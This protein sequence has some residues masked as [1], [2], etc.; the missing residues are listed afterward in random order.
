RYVTEYTYDAFSNQLT[1]TR[2]TN[3]ILEIYFTGSEAAATDEF[4]S[5]PTLNDVQTWLVVDAANDRTIETDY[6]LKGQSIEVR[7]PET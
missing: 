4:I 7:Q 1:T 5:A 3:A 2:Y 6:D